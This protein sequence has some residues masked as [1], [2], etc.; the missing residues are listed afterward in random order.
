[1]ILTILNRSQFLNLK[2]FLKENDPSA[3]ITVSETSEVLGE[4][5]KSLIQE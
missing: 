2:Q 5:F 4:G 3:F 1:M